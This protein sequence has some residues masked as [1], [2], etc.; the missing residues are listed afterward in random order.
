MDV[1]IPQFKY[2]DPY[3]VTGVLKALKTQFAIKIVYIIHDIKLIKLIFGLIKK[4]IFGLN[5]GWSQHTP[6]GVS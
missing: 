1:K 4:Y 5:R 6:A 3:P 2:L